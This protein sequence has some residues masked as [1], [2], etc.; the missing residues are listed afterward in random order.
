MAFPTI[1]GRIRLPND[2]AFVG[3]FTFL[4][5]SGPMF[6]GTTC[7]HL[8]P[9]IV[10]T[11]NDGDFETPLHPGLYIVECMRSKYRGADFSQFII[12]VPESSSTINFSAI[13]REG[14]A[15]PDPSF[16][17]GSSGGGGSV[18]AATTTDA[19]IVKVNV[20][21][22]DPVAVTKKS[23]DGSSGLG[24]IFKPIDGSIWL[25]VSNGNYAKLTAT[26]LQGQNVLGISQTTVAFASLPSA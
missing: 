3:T 13:P 11:N 26:V 4:R 10:T 1:T 12:R 14:P 24:V 8:A 15:L 21:D 6:N 17:G 22:A 19:G 5:K 2:A 7:V 9:V 16:F 20:S 25:Q 23:L 18:S